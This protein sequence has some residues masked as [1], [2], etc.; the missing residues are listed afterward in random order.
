MDFLAFLQSNSHDIF[1]F[2][3][4]VFG[5]LVSAFCAVFVYSKTR[6][7]DMSFKTY[8]ECMGM[9]TKT[10]TYQQEK[11]FDVTKYQQDFSKSH[12]KP[13]Y[14]YN[15]STGELTATGGYID[16]QKQIDSHAETA[17]DRVMA[18]YMPVETA[19]TIAVANHTRVTD[20]LDELAKII[21][22]ANKYKEMYN[23]DPA[24]SVNDVFK[25][26][27]EKSLELKAVLENYTA[28]TGKEVKTDEKKD[29]EQKSE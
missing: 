17:L 29:V 6:N 10:P 20:D 12:L 19:E 9:I 1:S 3:I 5:I 24:T 18:N 2:A 14:H 13:E 26:V 23:L 22:T 25:V 11:D 21:D 28:T 15:N 27:K 16:I 7:L 8:K 4:E